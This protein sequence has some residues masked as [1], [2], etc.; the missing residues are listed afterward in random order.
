MQLMIG[1]IGFLFLGGAGVTE[2]QEIEFKGMVLGAKTS[3]QTLEGQHSLKCDEKHRSQYGIICRG[4]TTFLGQ[5][6]TVEINLSNE[7]VLSRIY[8]RYESN[9]LKYKDMRKSFYE[10]FG[11]PQRQSGYT[12]EWR[13]GDGKVE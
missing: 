3:V 6:G 11:R 5:K 2:A 13:K 4:V 9:L 12:D 7:N 1:F 10:K 8:V